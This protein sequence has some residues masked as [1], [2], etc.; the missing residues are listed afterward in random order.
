MQSRVAR[1]VFQVFEPIVG[2]GYG[3]PELRTVCDQLGLGAHRMSYY[4]VRAAA[5]GSVS[6]EVISA[7]FYHHPVGL[8]APAIPRA[9][10]IASP[11]R[12]VVARFEAVDSALR[13]LLPQQIPSA[14]MAEAVALVREALVG[15]SVAGRAMFAGHA[16]LPW[17]DEPH[18]ALW[19]G[20]NCIREHRGDGHTS[21]VMMARLDPCQATVMLIASAGEDRAG[22]RARWS[23]EAWNQAV[24]ALQERGWLHDA[25]L[26]TTEG[27]AAR[28]RVEDET[29]ALALEPWLHL[30]EA[31]THRLWMLLRDFLQVMID[32][33]G[34]RLRTPLG[35]GWPAQ[36]PD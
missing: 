18:V 26:P 11:E 22:R 14:E 33:N 32:Q 21:A 3:A 28:T 1:A 2:V 20:L 9:W 30:G 36:W 13:R 16:A 35:L 19:H 17:P 15:C 29:D 8:V 23:D 25:G 12:I 4:A 5:L 6:A 31:Q 24:V 34:V 10:S 27:L 7:L